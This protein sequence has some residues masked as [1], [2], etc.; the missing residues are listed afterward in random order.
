[1]FFSLKI[2]NYHYRF[3]W[4]TTYIYYIYLFTGDGCNYQ[5]L[6]PAAESAYVVY[7]DDDSENKA[8][9]HAAYRQ[10]K[11]WQHGRFGYGQQACRPIVQFVGD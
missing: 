10:F 3:V 2:I 7:V 8:N 5:H 4:L 6:C 9:R 1:V 11:F